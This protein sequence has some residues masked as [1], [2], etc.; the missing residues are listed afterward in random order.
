MMAYW[1]R[2][3]PV[4]AVQ[5]AELSRAVSMP[6]LSAAVTRLFAKFCAA[7]SK[8][9]WPGANG[10]DQDARREV[11]AQNVCFPCDLVHPLERCVTDL[12]NQPFAEDEPP[13]R[14]GLAEHVDRQYLW[15]SYRHSV[16][17]ARSISL[18]MQNLLEEIFADE[19]DS[20]PLLV[21]RANVPL[22]AMFPEESRRA[23]GW[24]AIGHSLRTLWSL[25]RCH[26]R[27]PNDPN[28]F[29]M[30]F[31]I[32][33]E[34]LPVDALRQR[35]RDYGVTIGELLAASMVD[36]FVEQDRHS[37]TSLWSPNRCV[38]VLADLTGRASP[39][40]PRIF[41]QYL[42]PRNIMVNSR[43]R[44]SFAELVG[45]VKALSRMEHL[46]VDGLRSLRGLS[47]NS[48]LVGR[49]PR[50]F[51]NWYQERLF[52][53]SGA[54]SNVN[55]QS[56]LPP[57]RT[58]VPLVHYFRGTC[59][60]QFSPMI[61]CLTTVNDTCSLTTTHREAVYTHQ[62]MR[63]LAAHVIERA[64]GIE[65]ALGTLDADQQLP[66]ANPV[67]RPARRRVLLNDGRLQQIRQPNKVPN[68]R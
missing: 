55:L 16:A 25:Q 44:M 36:W 67:H 50:A 61:L 68:V 66:P 29:H 6:Q 9:R 12:L 41:G 48:F 21:D 64:F 56:V 10:S 19:P 1:E 35:A 8:N 51:A 45:T 15:L 11:V 47:M 23:A 5:I 59:A 43:R 57:P 14:V 7:D 18:L 39:Q 53:V 22:P 30:S 40:R 63:D 3:H 62:E 58:P 60:T 28:A 54:L 65:D 2:L 52:P 33:A 13:F 31:L 20:L 24:R 26:R 34:Q 32:H 49:C 46:V 37:P 4:N 17:D 27:P 42:A 38:S